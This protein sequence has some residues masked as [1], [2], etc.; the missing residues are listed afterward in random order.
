MVLRVLLVST[1]RAD[2][3]APELTPEGD[4]R[5]NLAGVMVGV[6]CVHE[7]LSDTQSFG[8]KEMNAKSAKRP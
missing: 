3:R 2:C 4:N 8:C 6:H 7:L 5:R 1:K